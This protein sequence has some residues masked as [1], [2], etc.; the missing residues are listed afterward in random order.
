MIAVL[1]AD[2]FE[3]IEALTPVDMLRR[4]GLDVKTV[5]LNGK[6]AAGSHK[7]P[8]ICDL[9]PA[10]V[11]LDK[12]SMTIFPG[13]MPGALNLDASPFTDKIIEATLKNGGRLAAICAAPLVLGRRGLLD[14]KRAT[15]YPGFEK[16]LTGANTTGECVVTDGN[17]TTAKGMGVA[18]DFA[19]ELIALILGEEKKNALSEA[20][21]EKK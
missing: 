21:M 13:G 1:L 5:G 9:E 14:G 18:L 12:V 20:I 6:I 15:C 19:N 17:I 3:E 8:V 10:E 4:A 2:G 16:E 7:I 11:E